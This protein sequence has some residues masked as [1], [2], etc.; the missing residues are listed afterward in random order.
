MNMLYHTSYLQNIRYKDRSTRITRSVFKLETDISEF[1]WCELNNWMFQCRKYYI[2][3]RICANC[4]VKFASVIGQCNNLSCIILASLSA[5]ITKSCI[6]IS[7]QSKS[8]TTCVD[9]RTHAH[10]VFSKENT[11]FTR[12]F[13][14][15]EIFCVI[16]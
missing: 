14:A 9:I 3:Y 6:T 11:N 2:C 4:I 13:L 7:L 1:N 15:I 8:Q 12:F 16:E 10:S 5:A